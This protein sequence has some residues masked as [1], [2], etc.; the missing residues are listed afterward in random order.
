MKLMMKCLRWC[1]VLVASAA[2][3]EPNREI[4]EFTPI[5][6]AADW[7]D[8][9]TP[10]AGKAL[11][12]TVW[13][14]DWSFDAP[15]GSCT[16]EG[17]V[18]HDNRILNDGSNYWSVNTGYAG[19]GSGRITGNAAILKKH[20]LCWVQD[21]YGNNWDYSLICKYSGATATLAFKFVADTE[22]DFDFIKVECDS[23]GLS[24]S[25]VDYN[26]D[27]AGVPSAFREEV[28]SNDGDLNAG[29]TVAPLM[30]SDFG[31]GIHEA[32][33]PFHR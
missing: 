17:W 6:A 22:A 18:P 33:I 28:Y 10:V 29:V 24:E 3:A 9:T 27:P 32:Y 21:G 4:H 30:L 2:A 13:I 12:D 8:A 23:L 20:D 25:R 7:N 19:A 5:E 26:V 31:P 11:Q 16:S 1:L 14:A 15:D